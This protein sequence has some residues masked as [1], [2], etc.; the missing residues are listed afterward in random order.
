MARSL[1]CRVGIVSWLAAGFAASSGVASSV[2][3]VTSNG[4]VVTFQ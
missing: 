4:C 2:N 3:T 1:F